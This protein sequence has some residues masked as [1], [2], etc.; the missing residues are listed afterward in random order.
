MPARTRQHVAPLGKV[1]P[2]RTVQ[3]QI[4]GTRMG[5][6]THQRRRRR[7]GGEEEEGGDEGRGTIILGI[8]MGKQTGVEEERRP[9]SSQLPAHPTGGISNNRPPPPPPTAHNETTVEMGRLQIE[10]YA[11]QAMCNEARPGWVCP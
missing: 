9:H 6:H 11:G 1:I 10:E 3:S 8:G 5:I 4:L 2:R 7:R